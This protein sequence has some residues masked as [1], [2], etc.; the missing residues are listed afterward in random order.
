MKTRHGRCRLPAED[1]GPLL[2]KLIGL[3]KVISPE[4][5]RQALQDTGRLGQRA[6]LLN[7][8]VML[9][10]VLA[11]GILTHLPIRQVFKHARRLRRAAPRWPGACRASCTPLPVR[12]LKVSC[13]EVKRSN[14]RDGAC[15]V[16]S[17]VD[18]TAAIRSSTFPK[19]KGV[20][21][22]TPGFI[23]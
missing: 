3:E 12:Q 13:A 1:T 11:M 2:D 6:C 21:L 8:E 4:Q 23:F 10:V 15:P 16:S 20:Q 17:T 19:T 14:C 7:H 22:R 18:N 9:W 5:I